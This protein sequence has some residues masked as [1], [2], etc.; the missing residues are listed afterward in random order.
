MRR[1][2]SERAR[3]HSEQFGSATH[4]R[5]Q[6]CVDQTADALR[7]QRDTL[8]N[9]RVFRDIQNEQLINPESQHIARVFFG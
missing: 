1:A 4:R 9:R 7:R 6:D 5:S 2:Q 8:V 3:R